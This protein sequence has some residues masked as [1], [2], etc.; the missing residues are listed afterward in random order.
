MKKDFLGTKIKLKQS[1]LYFFKSFLKFSLTTNI[2]SRHILKFS[3]QTVEVRRRSEKLGSLSSATQRNLRRNAICDVTYKADHIWSFS[4]LLQSSSSN[5]FVACM[6]EQKVLLFYCIT[7]MTS[8]QQLITSHIALR[9][10]LRCV[11]L[12]KLPNVHRSTLLVCLFV[13]LLKVPDVS[14]SESE[15]AEEYNI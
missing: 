5:F 14:V 7:L 4:R 10:R 8:Q 2:Y 1:A 11:A 13:C 15:F 9:R 6:F 12:L 3:F